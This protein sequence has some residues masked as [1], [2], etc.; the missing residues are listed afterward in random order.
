ML[1]PSLS[2]SDVEKFPDSWYCEMNYYDEAR[3]KCK[4]KARDARYMHQ[5]FQEQAYQQSMG[6]NA[7]ENSQNSQNSSDKN[8]KELKTPT[9]E[10]ADTKVPEDDEHITNTKRDEV[11]VGLLEVKASKVSGKEKNAGHQQ[12]SLIAK[13]Y[14]HDSLMKEA[15]KAPIEI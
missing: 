5:F 11:L 10:S 8:E 7:V 3:S 2:A 9:K 15:I 14:F 4:A 1:P 6:G 13:Y 12:S